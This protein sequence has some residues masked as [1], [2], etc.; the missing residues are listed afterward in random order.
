MNIFWYSLVSAYIVVAT[1]ETIVIIGEVLHGNFNFD[2]Y[3]FKQHFMALGLFHLP[4]FA[5]F[6]ILYQ[7][8]KLPFIADIGWGVGVS[9]ASLFILGVVLHGLDEFWLWIKWEKA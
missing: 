8:F 3:S 5:F 9:G 4:T 2:L 6:G 7:L 1:I